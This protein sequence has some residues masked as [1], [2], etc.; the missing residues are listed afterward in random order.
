[1]L[2]PL[3]HYH[4]TCSPPHA[5]KVSIMVYTVCL[6]PTATQGAWPPDCTC[7]RVRPCTVSAAGRGE[8]RHGVFAGHWGLFCPLR[9]LRCVRGGDAGKCGYSSP[10]RGHSAC[11]WLLCVSGTL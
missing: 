1:M 11:R 7:L 8:T 5:W 4:A 3:V 6:A 10:R 9:V 2:T